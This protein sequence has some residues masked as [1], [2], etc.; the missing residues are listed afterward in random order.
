MKKKLSRIDIQEI[1]KAIKVAYIKDHDIMRKNMDKLNR[2]E[3]EKEEEEF[4]G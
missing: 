2:R 3:Y 1:K 4:Y